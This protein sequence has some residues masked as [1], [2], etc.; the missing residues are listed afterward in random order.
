MKGA[1]DENAAKGIAASEFKVAWKKQDNLTRTD[2]K[3]DQT[4]VSQVFKTSKPVDNKAQ[5]GM[6]QLANGDVAIFALTKV[7]DGDLS[8]LDAAKKTSTRR[9]LSNIDGSELFSEYLDKVKAG[10]EIQIYEDKL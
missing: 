5:Y 3:L 8:K 2:S 9:T 1:A 10:A 4:I 6:V 7:V